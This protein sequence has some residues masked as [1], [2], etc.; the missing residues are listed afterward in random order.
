MI[1]LA[2]AC[3]RASARAFPPQDSVAVATNACGDTV[4]FDSLV[5][6]VGNRY[7]YTGLH[8]GQFPARTLKL[9]TVWARTM[10]TAVLIVM[11]ERAPSPPVNEIVDR[12]LRNPRLG[13]NGSG[14]GDE[15][16]ITTRESGRYDNYAGRPLDGWEVDFTPEDE[17]T[18]RLVFVVIGRSD[19]S[20][21]A[22]LRQS[23][24]EPWGSGRAPGDPV[25]IF[26]TNHHLRP[27]EIPVSDRLLTARIVGEFRAD[28]K[29][30][31]IERV[32]P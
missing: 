32:R 16:G 30:L 2:L 8:G 31:R 14:R 9:S 28:L 19:S 4:W 5:M 12:A 25:P 17:R 10:G 13:L 29:G 22:P 6:Q 11:P 1:A 20:V 7:L 18:V 21:A 3:A 23:W 15:W 24:Q 27:F 26:R